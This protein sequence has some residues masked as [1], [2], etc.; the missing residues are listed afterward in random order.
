VAVDE[1][2]GAQTLRDLF[3]SHWVVASFWSIFNSSVSGRRDFGTIDVM[4]SPVPKPAVHPSNGTV[5][6]M[7]TGAKESNSLAEED[8]RVVFLCAGK[9]APGSRMAAE[10]LALN[11]RS[12]HEEF[13]GRN[14]GDFARLLAFHNSAKDSTILSSVP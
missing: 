12:L 9:D 8:G 10:F 7:G 13:G 3:D 6:L 11:W 14:N 1:F 4:V 5:V 2:R